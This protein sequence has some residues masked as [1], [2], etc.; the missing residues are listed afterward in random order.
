[1]F[2]PAFQGRQAFAGIDS[3]TPRRRN[4]VH[5]LPDHLIRGRWLVVSALKLE[6]SARAPSFQRG[7]NLFGDF[8]GA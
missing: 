1:M 3:Q 7:Q 5:P 8:G 6:Y 4:L 2:D